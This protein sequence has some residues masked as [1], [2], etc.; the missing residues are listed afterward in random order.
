VRE[1]KAQSWLLSVLCWRTW[2]GLGK[3]GCCPAGYYCA[4]HA[5]R[6]LP[7]LTTYL[8]LSNPAL[9]YWS[10]F[11][12]LSTYLHFPTPLPPPSPLSP[13]LTQ[14]RF[15]H[16]IDNSGASSGSAVTQKPAMGPLC[17]PALFPLCC[18]QRPCCRV[19]PSWGHRPGA[20]HG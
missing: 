11:S 17:P 5:L 2:H 7:Y 13:P 9:Y 15:V 3:N 16:F 8:T 1:L 12:Y 4:V 6:R 19:A 10:Y 14:H 20:A 18:F